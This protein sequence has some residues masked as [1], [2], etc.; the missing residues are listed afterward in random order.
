MPPNGGRA[1][2]RGRFLDHSATR[3]RR[4]HMR[5]FSAEP[6]RRPRQLLRGVGPPPSPARRC[7]AQIVRLD[8]QFLFVARFASNNS[9]LDRL[10]AGLDDAKQVLARWYV[11]RRDCMVRVWFDSDEAE[12][13]CSIR[14]FYVSWK[15]WN[16]GR[17][18]D[19]NRCADELRWCDNMKIAR[20]IR[21]TTDD[22]VAAA[23]DFTGRPLP[24]ATR[25]QDGHSNDY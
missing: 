13:E 1:K 19:K 14:M 6:Q 20:S 8:D 3:I 16:D 25:D 17:A 22:V 18:I 5:R 12:Y 21:L 23:C 4:H 10:P 9:S 2:L 11:E 24:S 15:H 7:L